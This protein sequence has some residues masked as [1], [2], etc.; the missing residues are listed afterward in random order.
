MTG[1]RPT[2]SQHA[3][4]NPEPD[5]RYKVEILEV[6]GHLD[7]DVEVTAYVAKLIEQHQ[8]RVAVVY[9]TRGN[10][11][12]NAAGAEQANALA[13]IRETRDGSPPFACFLWHY[14]CLV[15]ARLGY[16]RRRCSPFPRT[17]GSR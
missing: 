1:I 5:S 11:G 15:P 8:K 13:N 4:P 6:I 17:V 2:Y 3:P 7:D 10:S 16:A 14:E 9:A 12:G